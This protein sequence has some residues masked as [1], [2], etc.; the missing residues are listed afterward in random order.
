MASLRELQRDFFAAL[1]QPAA[2]DAAAAH[3]ATGGLAPQRRLQIY[4]N[5]HL[6]S[7][8]AALEACFPV[9]AQLVGPACFS[10]LAQRFILEHP[11]A[12]G[13]LLD[14]GDTF[15]A[16]L[17]GQ[18][19]LAELDYLPDVARLEWLRQEAYHAGD[20]PRLGLQRLAEVPGA[21]QQSLRIGL[22]PSAR[23]FRSAYP[24]FSIWAAHQGAAEPGPIRLDSGAEQALVWRS[25]A[26]IEV[27][28]LEAGAAAMLRAMAAGETFAAACEAG[29]GAQD[30][31]DPGSTLARLC[32]GGVVSWASWQTH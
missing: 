12:R 17:A 1:R 25:P 28:R 27:A 13:H 18:P 3:L 2:N 19:E 5:N 22:Q 20:G 23:V 14:Y 7:L 31:F 16:F 11:P 8:T 26:G 30:G 10:A 24:V 32:A 4:H 15:P 21:G 29:L 6:L 9:V